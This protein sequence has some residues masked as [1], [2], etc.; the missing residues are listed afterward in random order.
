MR[1]PVKNSRKKKLN[2]ND[3]RFYNDEEWI[4]DDATDGSYADYLG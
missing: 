1:K 4:A 3:I 2:T